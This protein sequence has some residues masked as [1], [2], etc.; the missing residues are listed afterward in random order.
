MGSSV[1][2]LGTHSQADHFCWQTAASCSRTVTP[3]AATGQPPAR[4]QQ[5]EPAFTKLPRP[6]HS[7]L[8]KTLLTT[9][10]C[11][12]TKKKQSTIDAHQ[13]NKRPTGG[14]QWCSNRGLDLVWKESCSHLGLAMKLSWPGSL[15]LEG[16]V[17]AEDCCWRG[18]KARPSHGSISYV[19]TSLCRRQSHSTSFLADFKHSTY[20]G[21]GNKARF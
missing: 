14:S 1:F 18:P 7:I 13:G 3:Y 2:F 6:T 19:A 15:A 11:I 4:A 20:L 8:I 21:T 17:L 10:Y 5:A 9:G 16:Q 12:E